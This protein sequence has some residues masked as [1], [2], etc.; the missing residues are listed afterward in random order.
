MKFINFL[1]GSMLLMDENKD[2]D[3]GG[4]NDSNK[5]LDALKQQNADL[6]KR[7]EALEGKKPD[8]KKDDPS[9]ADKVRKEND[10]KDRLKKYEKSLESAINFSVASKDF[11]KLNASLLP[12][13]IEGI[14]QQ[15]DKEKYDSAIE[16]AN[17]IKVELVAEFFKIQNNFDL[18][19]SSQK[20]ELDDF[21][22][23]TKNGKL[24]KVDS[25]YSMIFE[26][27]LET[28]RKIE[29]AKQVNNSDK[30]Q[31]DSEK[32]LADKLMKLSKKHYLGDKDA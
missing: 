6:I 18:L 7:L 29:K 30:I 21:L 16:K 4:G 8:D 22:K 1:M 10:E 24:E 27:T 23:L 13:N 32:A 28:L 15:A 14:F 31:T 26:P 11:L 12:K 9:L 20:N 25:V 2:G 3:G 5:D 19:T 17:T